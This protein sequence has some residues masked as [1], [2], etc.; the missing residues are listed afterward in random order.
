MTGKRRLK[1]GLHTH[2]TLSD[3]HRTPEE[4]AA[5]YKEAGYDAMVYAGQYVSYIK[6]DMGALAPYL[7][8]Y[9]EYKS[10]SSEKLYPSFY[11]QM[12]Y[13]QYSSSI[14]VDGIEG[15]V[16]GNLKFIR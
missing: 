3:G 10:E 7:C 9:P 8:W 12:D 6:Y 11:Y 4:V 15:S 16:D 1:I 14:K 13:W 5:I 2:T